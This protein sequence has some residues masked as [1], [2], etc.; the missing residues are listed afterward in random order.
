MH[1]G[2]GTVEDDRKELKAG[3]TAVANIKNR[4]TYTSVPI[5]YA[6]GLGHQHPITIMLR[7][8]G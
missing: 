4:G 6:L 5:S 8:N 3:S 7:G 1:R 2:S